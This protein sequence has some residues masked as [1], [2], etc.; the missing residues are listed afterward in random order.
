MNKNG[1]YDYRLP[2]PHDKDKNIEKF[3][4]RLLEAEEFTKQG[5]VRY[6]RQS[7]EFLVNP[8]RS[9]VAESLCKTT[10]RRLP[11]DDILRVTNDDDIHPM[12]YNIQTTLLCDHVQWSISSQ[13]RPAKGS[14]TGAI[15][16]LFSYVS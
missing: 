2:D 12:D 7:Y 6:P 1:F 13:K 16:L 4:W 10:S 15:R 5:L 11:Y 3:F 14:S 9:L 8:S